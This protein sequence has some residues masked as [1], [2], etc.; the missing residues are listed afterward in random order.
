MRWNEFR[1]TL[2]ESGL[3][4]KYL[5]KHRGQYLDVL[6]NLI[7]TNKDVELEGGAR[8]KHG[9]TVKFEK[10]DAKLLANLFYGK[11]SPVEDKEDVNADDNGYLIPP[12]PLPSSVK[13]TVQGTGEKISTGD[14]LK[15]PE[16]KGSKKDF[17]TG[18]VGEAFLGA[19]A[20]AKFEK[21]G[22]DITEDDVISV[23]K[24]MTVTEEGK[25]KRG[26]LNSNANNDSLE[27]V[28]VLN[29]TSFGAMD[30]SVREGKLPP[31]MIGLCRSA[32]IWANKSS[33]MANAVQAAIDDPEANAIVVNSDGV[34]DQKGT[35]ADLFLTIDESTVNLLSAKAGDVKQFGQVPGNSYDKIEEFFRSMFGV[36]V[37][38]S[39]IEQMNG[40]DARHNYP[41]FKKIYADVAEELENELKGNT[42][43]EVK[44]VQR[45][46]NGIFKHATLNDA[47]VS[48]VILKATPNAPGFTEL[49]FGPELKTAMEQF[50]LQV[51][52]QADP[53]RIQIHGRPV[54]QDALEEITGK[55][56]LVQLRTNLKGDSSK[57]YIR[58]VIEMGALLK[59]IAAVEKDIK[60]GDMGPDDATVPA[61]Q[62]APEPKPTNDPNA[63]I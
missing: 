53:P 55:T 27:Y 6:I 38:D 45:L 37:N 3:S 30:R 25:N 51:S 31:E 28:L 35:K 10:S 14:V 36:N 62:K 23:L 63:T 34:S 49:S 40:N 1:T 9:K 58:S 5:Q 15:T 22:E 33:A 26:L 57:G 46:Y 56:L 42:V 59:S 8:D 16:M 20:T 13:L 43:Q 32:V 24:R 11:N 41:I 47:K 54:G 2:N 50:D 7:A 4:K 39:Y 48:M 12:A 21:L 60:Q 61:D 52:Y 18:D 17:N 29:Q 19:A 44:F